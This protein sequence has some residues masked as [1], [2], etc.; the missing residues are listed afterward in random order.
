MP[1]KSPEA[2][3]RKRRRMREAAAKRR[4]ER[5]EAG[6]CVECGAPSGGKR[7][8]AECTESLRLYRAGLR[9][10]QRS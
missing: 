1:A 6:V 2:L 7:R 8:C 5:R 4:S 9:A 10:R 3:E